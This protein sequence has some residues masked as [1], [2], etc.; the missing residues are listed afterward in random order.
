VKVE[1]ARSGRPITIMWQPIP[2]EARLPSGR[3]VDTLL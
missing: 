2:V 1:V 3:R